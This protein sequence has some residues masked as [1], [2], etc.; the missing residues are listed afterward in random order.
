VERRS[1][2]TAS[3]ATI[4]LSELARGAAVCEVQV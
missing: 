1:I 4:S 3:S 2:R